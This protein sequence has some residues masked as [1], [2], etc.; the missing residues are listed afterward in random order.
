MKRFK[1]LIVILALAVIISIGTMVTFDVL[2]EDDPIVNITYSEETWNGQGEFEKELKWFTNEKEVKFTIDLKEKY[3]QYISNLGEGE[4]PISSSEIQFT[5]NASIEANGTNN[6]DEIDIKEVENS[7]GIYEVNIKLPVDV[8]DKLIYGEKPVNIAVIMPEDNKW[9]SGKFTKNF[10]I[11]VDNTAPVVNIKNVENNKI[12]ISDNK[13]FFEITEENYSTTDINIEVIRDG[14]LEEVED[15]KNLNTK[16]N[17]TNGVYEW[18]PVKNGIYKINIT[19]VDKAGNKSENLIDT[20]IDIS[21]YFEVRKAD[22]VSEVFANGEVLLE[23]KKTNTDVEIKVNPLRENATKIFYL[24]NNEEIIE[25]NE[26]AKTTSNKKYLLDDNNNPTF[27]YK[28]TE[29]GLYKLY[30]EEQD[31]TG[32][33]ITLQ[34]ATFTI[35]KSSPILSVVGLDNNGLF[36]QNSNGIDIYNIEKSIQLKLEDSDINLDSVK[37]EATRNGN[38]YNDIS[39]NKVNNENEPSYAEIN[40]TFKDGKYNIKIYSNDNSGNIIE[41]AENGELY[42]ELNFIID[43]NKPIITIEEVSDG[44][45]Y[46]EDKVVK[47]T[48]TD[49]TL[50]EVTASSVNCQWTYSD[51]STKATAEIPFNNEGIYNLVITA[52]DEINSEPEV[53]NITFTIDKS[54]PVI[55][56][57]G[58]ENNSINIE[59]KEVSISIT[60]LTL[61]DQ[62]ITVTRNGK[63]YP[64][65]WQE[66]TIVN[67]INY[68]YVFGEGSY[69]IR[70]DAIDELNNSEPKEITF[71]VDKEK[72][73]INIT[74]LDENN[75]EE[76]LVDGKHYISKKMLITIEDTTLN[77]DSI[78]LE[79]NGT[80]INDVQWVQAEAGTVATYIYDSNINGNNN[81][82]VKASD[83]AGHDENQNSISYFIDNVKPEITLSGIEGGDI[84]I[85]PKN[86]G[87]M[88]TILVKEEN[89][90]N[91]TVKIEVIKDSEKFDKLPN[92][93]NTG[94]ESSISYAFNEDGVYYIKVTSIDAAGNIAD[95]KD[96][97]FTIDGTVPE[98]VFERIENNEEIDNN[99]GRELT[100]KVKDNNINKKDIS[101]TVTKDN[102]SY[103]INPDWKEL[104]KDGKRGRKIGYYLNLNFN[105]D[106]HYIISVNATDNVSLP[107]NNN[108]VFTIDGAKPDIKISGLEENGEEKDKYGFIHFNQD[109]NISITVSD[110]NPKMEGDKFVAPEFILTKAGEENP[111]TLESL[112]KQWTLESN[113][114]STDVNLGEGRYTLQVKYSDKLGHS[115]ES[116]VIKFV[117]DKTAPTVS[118][119]NN[120]S[121]EDDKSV[122]GTESI[123]GFK[124]NMSVIINDLNAEFINMLDTSK[125]SI[126]I[127]GV[128]VSNNAYY[129]AEKK[130]IVSNHE[131]GEGTH[132]I[133]VEVKDIAGNKSETKVVSFIIDT[134]AP[135]LSI[136]GVEDS[137][138]YKESVKLSAV[139]KDATL[140]LDNK[141]TFL[142]VIR[143]KTI[144]DSE[145]IETIYDQKE[146]WTLISDIEAKLEFEIPNTDEGLYEVVLESTDKANRD[147]SKSTKTI[148]FIVDNRDPEIEIINTSKNNVRISETGDI[149]D[150][151]SNIKVTISD[152]Y[153]LFNE[154]G[155]LN[156]NNSITI[157]GN[158]VNEGIKVSE[159]K[160]SVILEK[161]FSE[162]NY[163]VEVK[164]EDI[165]GRVNNKKVSFTVDTSAPL[166]E[167]NNVGDKENFDYAPHY[168]EDKTLEVIVKDTTLSLGNDTVLSVIKTDKDGKNPIELIS[169]EDKLEL[170]QGD[171]DLQVAKFT[172][173]IGEEGYYTVTLSSND[174]AGHTNS[175]TRCFVID[176]TKPSISID[177]LSKEGLDNDVYYVKTSLE[178]SNLIITVDELNNEKDNVDIELFKD[179]E[180]I[181]LPEELK[182]DTTKNSVSCYNFSEGVYKVIVN[183]EDNAG[184]KAEEKSINFIVD[185]TKGIITFEGINKDTFNNKDNNRN[186]KI[187]VNELNF[188][189]N[190]VTVY[191]SKD[192]GDFK[193]LNK[194]INEGENTT[195]IN[196][197]SSITEL[198]DEDGYYIVKVDTVD[199]AGNINSAQHSFIIDKQKPI[200]KVEGFGNGNKDINGYIHYKDTQNINVEVLDNNLLDGIDPAFN[201]YKIEGSSRKDV[202]KAIV[203]ENQWIINKTIETNVNDSYKLSFNV[204]NKTEE[205]TYEIEL[206]YKDKAENSS[207]IETVKFIVDSTRPQIELSGVTNNSFNNVD[208]NLSITVDETNFNNN[209]VIINAKRNG[210]DY[211]LGQ[212]TNSNKRSVLSHMF[213]LDGLYE[214]TV[215]ATDF[216]GNQGEAKSIVFTIDKTNPLIAIEGVVNNEHYNIDKVLSIS[217]DDNN[218]NIN[219]IDVRRSGASYNIGSLNLSGTIASASYTFSQEGDYVVTVNSTDKAGN[220]S[221]KVMKFT[222]D[223]TAPVI[224]PKFSGQSRVIKNGEFINEIFTPVF[225]LDKAEDTI[226]SVTLNNGANIKDNIPVASKEEKYNYNVVAKDK[227]G[228]E[229]KLAVSFTIDV[230]KPELNLAGIVDAFFNKGVTPRYNIKDKN[231]D[232]SKTSVTLNGAS[233]A[234]GTTIENEG[235]YTLK[236]VATDLANNVTRSTILFTID[237]TNPRIVFKD[238]ISGKYFTETIIPQIL[239]EDMTEYTIITQTL[240][241][242]PYKLGDKIEGEGK[243]VLFLEVKDKSGNITEQTIEFMID[244]IK[245]KFIVDGVKNNG[246]YYNSVDISIILDNPFDTIK[247]ILINDELFEGEVVEENG[248]KIINFTLS[249][250]KDYE[251]KLIGVDEAGN[252]CEEI[253]T[254]KIAEKNLLV[255]AYENKIVFVGVIIALAASIVA[256]GVI[257]RTKKNKATKVEE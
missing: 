46:Y 143:K 64:I 228:N 171:S 76:T 194:W 109:R 201:I 85:N 231:L 17:G 30:T 54:N 237:K 115:S 247:S 184:N 180:R 4:T 226:V 215:T 244:T 170:Q 255:K 23:E 212:W 232:S 12:Y 187:N 246:R 254:F 220:K 120:S 98:I 160:Q 200:L 94:I 126:I 214:I 208:K 96:L 141:N 137:K 50:K 206:S 142:K 118:I 132:S 112:G 102:K 133:K 185:N 151:N 29:E 70:V 204:D 129:D 101:I 178:T 42:K 138:H 60:D 123:F 41:G 113:K 249:E 168:N 147:D 172:K 243:H 174:N 33:N 145:A 44:E 207:K 81:I 5:I 122:N 154:D 241:G 233:F 34:I 38:P 144:N 77:L 71:K 202:T 55:N 167:I 13:V 159:D 108:L 31:I 217:V 90:Q 245:P 198:F 146:H 161:E 179:N 127:N 191:I 15:L 37:V 57:T 92:W 48:V 248:Q 58:V 210:L 175:I 73:I 153:L 135:Q 74:P 87:N 119:I 19:A 83:E 49:T 7:N 136:N 253:L 186:L 45:K 2:S 134:T 95:T 91:N 130:C 234:S 182:W 166:L 51:Y 164:G 183:A 121:N 155:I 252:E 67:G 162:G 56:I 205:G 177:G 6:I 93:D 229:S 239:I 10:M 14:V 195:N 66:E 158:V 99:A 61:K 250:N 65:T 163:I 148:I 21:K 40:H 72:P 251:M 25:K 176:K 211:D 20:S 257:F 227:A 150:I 26:G 203:G 28:F 238:E 110:N 116:E 124:S 104:R 236:L 216:V 256:V 111:I 89:Y 223:K 52:S 218:H 165:S 9:N 103:P 63:D 84:P 242:E 224:T 230:T 125:A 88:L 131:F 32:K 196:V 16:L 225:A 221:S 219:T 80:V 114:F 128:E 189:N 199:K 22:A 78:I 140:N 190:K 209:K 169:S 117:V 24:M 79:N 82:I 105:D 149:F 97:N 53:K 156:E 8:D 11:Q 59:D 173:I 192:N 193:E 107:G 39:I 43:T 27:E 188:K 197:D 222:I 152:L 3:E 106:G 213:T 100:I 1:S 240:D 62:G 157:N 139:V 68:K 181:E 18:S 36:G 69:R 86:G 35:D 75:N 235:E 47:V